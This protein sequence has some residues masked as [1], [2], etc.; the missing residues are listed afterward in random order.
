MTT[1]MMLPTTIP[2]LEAFR[3]LTR[4]RN[5]RH[6][7]L[8]LV[9]AGYLIVWLLF[10]GIAHA[11]D[12]GIHELVQQTGWLV[13]NGWMLGALVLS[14]AG[15]FQFSDLKY[16][17]LEQC[18]AP[19]SFVLRHWRGGDVR[20]EALFIGVD[21]GIYCVGCCWAL[22]LLMFIVGTGSVGWMLLLGAVMAIEKNVAAGRHLS[23]PLGVAL[24][25]GA[26]FITLQNSVFSSLS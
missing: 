24:I 10:G 11:L 23:K 2:L 22:M 6:Q 15:L 8:L 21:H 20:R 19:L 7:L 9:V 14:V 1:A 4:A 13:V 26:I 17:C 25:V 12:L 18:R 16:R 5:D 3:R